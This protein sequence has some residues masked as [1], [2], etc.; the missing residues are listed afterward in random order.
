M[1][2]T[3]PLNIIRLKQNDIELN[4]NQTIK[5]LK[6]KN[7]EIIQIELLWYKNKIIEL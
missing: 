4:E 6:W 3:L 1:K 7:N 2:N 5:E